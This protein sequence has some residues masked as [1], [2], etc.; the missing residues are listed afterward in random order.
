MDRIPIETSPLTELI[1]GNFRSSYIYIFFCHNTS[2]NRETRFRRVVGNCIEPGVGA[3]LQWYVHRLESGQF[4]NIKK[5]TYIV[6]KFVD[7][8]NRNKIRSLVSLS[9]YNN[10]T[11]SERRRAETPQG[12]VMKNK[13]NLPKKISPPPPIFRETVIKQ[14]RFIILRKSS[15]GHSIQHLVK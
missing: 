8:E 3:M 14:L 10:S 11:K 7:W 5:W 15:T 4:W 13:I 1:S 2:H 9:F 12:R 6:Q